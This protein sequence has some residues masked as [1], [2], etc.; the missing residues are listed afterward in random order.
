MTLCTER[1]RLET[2][3]EKEGSKRILGCTEIAELLY[4][5]SDGVG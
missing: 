5:E 2:L 3:E 4:A 1:E